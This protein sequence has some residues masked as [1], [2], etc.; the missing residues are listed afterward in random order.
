MIDKKEKIIDLGF[1]VNTP[2]LLDEISKNNGVAILKVPLN[3]LQRW[4]LKLAERAIELDDP[5]LNIIMLSM[6]LYDGTPNELTNA[7]QIQF[8]RIK[9]IQGGNK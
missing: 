5:E 4:L 8:E 7:I 1:R 2:Q 6:A 3:V 9:K